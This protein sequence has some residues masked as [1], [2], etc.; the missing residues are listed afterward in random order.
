[1]KEKTKHSPI[2]FQF[3]NFRISLIALIVIISNHTLATNWYVNDNSTTG[4]IYCSA[5][6]NDANA[7]TASAPFGSFKHALTVLIPATSPSW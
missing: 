5:V 7:G 1:M 3:M 2:I 4:D 6:G